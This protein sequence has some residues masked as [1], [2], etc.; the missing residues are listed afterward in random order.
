M[1]SDPEVSLESL[2][3]RIPTRLLCPRQRS[4]PCSSSRPVLCIISST[5][6]VTT[7]VVIVVFVVVVELLLLLLLI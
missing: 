4:N 2:E 6:G 7:N 3:A 5:A 1:G